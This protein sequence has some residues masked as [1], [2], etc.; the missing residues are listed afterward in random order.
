MLGFFIGYCI[1]L[2]ALGMDSW[3]AE[4]EILIRLLQVLTRLLNSEYANR[5]PDSQ[6]TPIVITQILAFAP[7]A[8]FQIIL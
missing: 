6:W 3:T 7:L 4:V 1:D 5:I 2:G 8:R